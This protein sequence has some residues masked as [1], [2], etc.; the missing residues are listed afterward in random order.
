MDEEIKSIEEMDNFSKFES[1]K[2]LFIFKNLAKIFFFFLFLNTIY[3]DILLIQGTNN[4]QTIIQRFETITNQSPVQT[5][6]PAINPNVCP[7]G[8]LSQIN[9]VLASIKPVAAGQASPTPISNSSLQTS[10]QIKEYYIP[11]GSGSGSS[12]DW[13]DV[14]G[15]LANVDSAAYGTIKSVKFEASLH[16]PNGNQTASVRLYNATDNHPVWN[17]DLNFS[18]NSSSVLLISANVNLNSGNKQYKVQMKTQLQYEAVLDQS[19]LHML[20]N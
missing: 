10:S 8:C 12:A 6:V 15:L 14:P 16:V 5:P 11:F 4:K 2:K 19:R 20:A 18:G 9:Q 3:I 1:I 7:Q 17:S 13:Q